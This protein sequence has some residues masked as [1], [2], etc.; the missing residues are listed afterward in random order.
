MKPDSSPARLPL[1][2][3]PASRRAML[4]G[5]GTAVVGAAAIGL[6]PRTPEPDVATAAIA[7]PENGGGYRLSEH[8]KRYYATTLV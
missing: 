6:A 4:F 7:A 5:A 8:V 2:S 3:P 1:A